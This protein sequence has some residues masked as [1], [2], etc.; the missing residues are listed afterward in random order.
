MQNFGKIKQYISQ[1]DIWANS[2]KCYFVGRKGYKF[3]QLLSYSF[4]HWFI[5]L[6]IYLLIHLFI[7]LF[8][9]SFINFVCRHRYELSAVF[10]FLFIYLSIYLCCLQEWV[11]IPIAAFKAKHFNSNKKQQKNVFF[12][13][14]F[15][16]PLIK[17][18][19]HVFK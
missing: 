6:L 10:I 3:F 18:S 17:G 4:I 16:S 2:K 11:Q 5:Y 9:Y 7:H 1:S 12:F 8:I 14:I 13:R 15:W 19:V